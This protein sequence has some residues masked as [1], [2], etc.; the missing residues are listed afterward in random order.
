MI[1]YVHRNADAKIV[2]AAQYAQDG[3]ATEQ[4]DDTT[5][6][7]LQAFLAPGIPTS[8][9]NTQLKRE[10][11]ALGK[12]SAAVSAVTAAGGLTLQL[13]YGAGVFDRTDPL[14]IQMATALGM[15]SADLDSAFIAAAKL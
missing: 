9:T 11:D 7:E 13:W 12:L 3:Y 5:S 1:W 6:A 10:L 2:F 14:L 15:T 4:L 8:V